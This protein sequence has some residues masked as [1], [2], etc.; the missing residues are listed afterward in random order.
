MEKYLIRKG[1]SSSQNSGTDS[2][3]SGTSVIETDLSQTQTKEEVKRKSLKR[4]YNN[5]YL[6]Y[7]IISIDKEDKSISLCVLR[8]KTLSNEAL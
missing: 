6:K 3:R 7:S 8:L 4:K 2:S 1:S 5:E